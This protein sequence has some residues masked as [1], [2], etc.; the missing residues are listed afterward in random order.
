[1]EATRF[2]LR[3]QSTGKF[4]VGGT[5]LGFH[6]YGKIWDKIGGLKACL[7]NILGYFQYVNKR[8]AAHRDT[9]P[10]NWEVV[11]VKIVPIRRAPAALV[12]N[13]EA[14]RHCKHPKKLHAKVKGKELKCLTDHTTYKDPWEEIA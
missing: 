5:G 8:N 11:E 6:E 13:G 2:M 12:Q 10:D 3:D 4:H 9:I 7:T 14:C 1:M